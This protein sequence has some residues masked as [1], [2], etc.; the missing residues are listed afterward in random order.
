MHH[1]SAHNA[2]EYGQL[3]G[4]TSEKPSYHI[5]R[6]NAA[7]NYFTKAEDMNSSLKCDT[8]FIGANEDPYQHLSNAPMAA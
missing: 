5:K 4:Q 7:K 1:S 6:L 2:R 8:K 3:D